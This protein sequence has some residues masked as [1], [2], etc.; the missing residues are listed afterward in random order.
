MVKK[1]ISI[2]NVLLIGEVVVVGIIGVSYVYECFR[3]NKFSKKINKEIEKT[4]KMI[5]ELTEMYTLSMID[6][7]EV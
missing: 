4:K 2:L 1:I 5:D 3:Y 6:K 7:E